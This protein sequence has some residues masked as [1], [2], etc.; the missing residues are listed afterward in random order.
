M[1][2]SKLHFLSGSNFQY[3]QRGSDMEDI[4]K[5]E[6][7]NFSKKNNKIHAVVGEILVQRFDE[8]RKSHKRLSYLTE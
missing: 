6:G 4:Q 5:N 3:V 7:N 2:H 1:V 8:E